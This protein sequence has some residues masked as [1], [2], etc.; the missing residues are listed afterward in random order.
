MRHFYILFVLFYC[1]S[2]TSVLAQ[3]DSIQKLDEVIIADTKLTEYAEGFQVRSLS[4]SILSRDNASLTDVLRYNSSIYFKENGYG[5]VSS[6]SFRGTN[7]SQTA[8]IWNGISINSN[9]NGQTDFNLIAPNSSDQITI[10]SGGGSVQYGSGAI[11]GSIH[12][13]NEIAFRKN[14]K[15]EL[16]ISYGSYETSKAIFKSVTSSDNIYSSVKVSYINS[17]NDYKYLG[18]GIK[19]ENG[20]FQKLN[21]GYNFGAR[22]NNHVFTWNSNYF[23]GDRNFSSSITAPSKNNYK[24]VTTR[25][26]LSWTLKSSQL[27][28]K[29]KAAHLFERYRYFPD[30]DKLLFSEGKSNTYIADYS[31]DYFASKRLKFNAILNYTLIDAKGSNIGSNQRNTLSAVLLMQH[32]VSSIL[33]YGLNVR[34]EFLNDFENPLLI[35]LDGKLQLRPWYAIKVNASKNYRVPT[36][37][38]LFWEA[39]GNIGLA[40]ETSLQAELGQVFEF[41]NLKFNLNGFFIDSKDLISW[42]PNDSGF[43]QPINIAETQNYG[44]EVT[45]EYLKSFNQHHLSVLMNYSYTKATNKEKNNQL[46]YV[47][48]HKATG[49]LNYQFKK[50]SS[51]YQ[52]LYTGKVFTTTDNIGVVDPY[53]VCNLGAEYQLNTAHTPITIGGKINNIF[54]IYYENVAYRPMPDRNFQLF[55]NFKF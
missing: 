17:L 12:L 44:L 39:G 7:S 1:A 14:Q 41:S 11:G 2:S 22:F 23:Y 35:S 10:R 53:W 18:K 46:L 52:V 45:S 4:D 34:K 32:K 49:L 15:N 38:D 13:N 50:F 5:M 19:N 25:N 24:D 3:L 8:V 40:P 21:I 55:I 47:P 33:S 28:S 31:L 30:K 9:L 16:E 36:F 6:P 26:L 27:I 42:R 29:F 37:N 54:N 48:F 43:W 20:A 51:Y